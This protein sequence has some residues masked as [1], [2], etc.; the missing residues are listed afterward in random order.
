MKKESV[1]AIMSG[2]VLGIII[3]IFVLVSFK[4][5]EIKEKKTISVEITPT[6][7]V[8][9][10][11]NQILEIKEPVTDFI[12]SKKDIVIKGKAEKDSLIVFSSSTTEKTLKNK[13][14]DFE[15]SFPLSLGENVI[16]I[17]SYKNKNT[18]E[19]LL[20]IYFLEE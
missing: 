7:S 14:E 19:K 18:E 5:K 10:L 1:V 16:R 8:L 11:K 20:K 4:E 13:T 6:V 17:A 2:I 3:A 12:S 15:I 9:N